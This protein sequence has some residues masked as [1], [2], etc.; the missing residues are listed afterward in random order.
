MFV[1]SCGTSWYKFRDGMFVDDELKSVHIDMIREVCNLQCRT[2]W[3]AIAKRERLYQFIALSDE[4]TQ[5]EIRRELR[6]L[7]G[8]VSGNV[9]TMSDSLSISGTMGVSLDQSGGKR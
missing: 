4:V 3:T 6:S 1:C 9:S 7:C 5:L 2:R 8:M